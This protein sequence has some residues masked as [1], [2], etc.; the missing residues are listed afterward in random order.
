MYATTGRLDKTAAIK[1]YA[2]LVKRMAHHMLAKLPAN[3]ELDDIVQAGLIGLMD[4]VNRYEDNQGA[5]FE[6]YATQRIK[7]AM[8][9]EL[10]AAD[11]LPRSVRKNQRGIESAIHALQQKLQRAPTETEIAKEMGLGIN[12]YHSMLADARGLQLVHIEDFSG[13]E[14]D[15]DYLDRHC[16]D[17]AGDPFE[18]MRDDR[19]RKALIASIDEL[20]E[21]ERHLMGMYYEQDMNFREIAAVLGVTESRVC[22]LHTQAVSRLRSKLKAW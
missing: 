2:P 4:A 22:Q 16:P 6:T 5:Q 10:R 7:G 20:P 17:K 1:Q 12:E 8:L 9:D 19:F 14:D 11:W 13:G 21:R 3:V 18:Q 15:D